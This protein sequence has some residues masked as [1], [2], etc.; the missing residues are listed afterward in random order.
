MPTF[1]NLKSAVEHFESL[2]E[3]KVGP[4]IFSF[5]V[6]ISGSRKFIVVNKEDFWKFY[7]TLKPRFHYEVI[8]PKM[9]CKLYFD[10][11]FS[12][13]LNIHKNGYFMVKTLINLVNDK[14]SS[15]YQ[16]INTA[17]N[18]LI[19][20]S[21]TKNK[22]S[23]HLV[24]PTIIFENNIQVGGFVDNFISTL[25]IEDRRIFTVQSSVV[26]AD[27]LFIDQSVYKRNQQF[28][29]FMSTKMGKN[30]PLI[31]SDISSSPHKVF[32]KETFY[33]SLITNVDASVEAIKTN[34]VTSSSSHVNNTDTRELMSSE[35]S[36]FSEI[37]QILSDI[38]F[39]GRI[40]GWTYHSPSQTYCY[41]VVGYSYC[42][43]VQRSHSNSKVYFLFCVRNFSLWQQC[44]SQKC[45][46]YKSD[47][48]Q[49]PDFSWFSEEFED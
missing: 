48:L 3:P 21:F 33:C 23:C 14:L 27:A 31:V 22:F 38:V 5:Q 34:F 43:N 26:D 15:D 9:K 32:N 7:K 20:E 37:D 46:D 28:R 19:L 49:I 29:L 42:R 8:L 13:K 2:S 25:S 39:P 4:Y 41:N 17:N 30:N 35:L 6:D 47:C 44:W 16:V 24:F 40:T 36:P 10:L 1:W 12:K 18:V 11:E 45:R